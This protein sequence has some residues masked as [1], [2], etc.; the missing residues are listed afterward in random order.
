M[1]YI[2]AGQTSLLQ[3]QWEFYI[4]TWLPRL[5]WYVIGTWNE[6]DIRLL[7]IPQSGKIIVLHSYS[8]SFFLHFSNFWHLPISW[9]SYIAEL[10]TFALTLTPCHINKIHAWLGE[11]HEQSLAPQEFRKREP[12]TQ[13]Y[14]IR[15][16]YLAR[17]REERFRVPQELKEAA[18]VNSD[19][20]L[21]LEIN[22][23][24]L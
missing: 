13:D 6:A 19:N 15:R 22:S 18:S 5:H 16:A 1:F 12:V 2:S 20:R 21:P 3:V 8:F 14:D 4:G 9:M 23:D 11:S 17:K 24:Y 7:T 10:I